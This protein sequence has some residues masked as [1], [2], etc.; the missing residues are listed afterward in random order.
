MIFINK[1][2]RKD[3]D[4]RK[5]KVSRFLAA[6]AI[7]PIMILKN[8]M[9]SSLFFLIILVQFIL[10]HIVQGK[11]ASAARHWTKS[12]PQTDL[13]TFAFASDSILLL[14]RSFPPQKQRRL[15]LWCH[16]RSHRISGCKWCVHGHQLDDLDGGAGGAGG[17]RHHP[18]HHHPQGH[19]DQP[20]REGHPEVYR[21]SQ[22]IQVN[23]RTFASNSMY[24]TRGVV[25]HRRR[26][27]QKRRHRSS[28]L[29]GGGNL[30]NSMPHYR[31]STK[32][33]W[34]KG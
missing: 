27:R 16:H 33:I 32:M 21:P 13:T 7:L 1:I 25:E 14:W 17:P 15:I 4:R 20:H 12:A 11:T 23:T 2:I 29:F 6:L 31:F 22:R 19:E 3:K 8:R 26:N 28:L 9:N 5:G 24:E 18:P 34:N 30:F 10:I